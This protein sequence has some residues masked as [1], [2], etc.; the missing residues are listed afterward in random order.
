MISILSISKSYKQGKETLTI[1]KNL[2]LEVTKGQTVAIV[3]PSGSGKSTLLSIMAGLDSPDEGSVVIDGVDISTLNEQ[4]LANLRNKKIS[5]RML[6]KINK[7]I[8]KS[9]KNY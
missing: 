3:G 9:S 1:L 4:D 6:E 5:I 2:S 7:N 8:N